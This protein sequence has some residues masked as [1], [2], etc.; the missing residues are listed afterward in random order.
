[1]QSLGA[2]IA[3]I[4]TSVIGAAVSLW[5][6]YTT[7][8]ERLSVMFALRSALLIFASA[9]CALWL[10]D[11][12]GVAA[13]ASAQG[14]AGLA[15]RMV[16]AVLAVLTFSAVLGVLGRDDLRRLRHGLVGAR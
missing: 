11:A 15:G 14:A 12:Q 2:V 3:K 13:L 16:L 7:L 5:L 1:M 8:G 10:I 4:I 6:L 9:A